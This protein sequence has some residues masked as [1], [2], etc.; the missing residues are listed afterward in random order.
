MKK[1]NYILIMLFI[2]R[3]I[4]AVFKPHQSFND[5]THW[6][7][8]IFSFLGQPLLFFIVF[9]VAT[10]SLLIKRENIMH[11]LSF[12]IALC[13]FIIPYLVGQV[14]D[15]VTQWIPLFGLVQNF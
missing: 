15:F 10:F 2:I 1:L 3:M 5:S 9:L 8:P 11:S 13:Y 14:V 6:Y 12:S 4:N 7:G